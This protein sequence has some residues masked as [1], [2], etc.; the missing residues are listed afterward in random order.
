MTLRSAVVLQ[1]RRIISTDNS[2]VPPCAYEESSI[3]HAPNT[4][5]REDSSVR[6]SSYHARHNRAALFFSSSLLEREISYSL[7][8]PQPDPRA[9]LTNLVVAWM[10]SGNIL[11]CHNFFVNMCASSIQNETL[12]ICSSLNS[13]HLETGLKSRLLRRGC[14]LVAACRTR[15]YYCVLITRQ[16]LIIVEIKP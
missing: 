7:E 4:R 2:G 8:L 6:C 13:K 10:F 12:Q 16:S 11:R 1:V 9:E 5:L 3:R 14:R 15:F